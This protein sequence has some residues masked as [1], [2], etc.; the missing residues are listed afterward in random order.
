LVKAGEWSPE[1]VF[2]DLAAGAFGYADLDI[3]DAVAAQVES[4]LAFATQSVSTIALLNCEGAGCP[5]KR[6][7]A[8]FQNNAAPQGRPC[9]YEARLFQGWVEELVT[10][11]ELD[12]SDTATM[13]LIADVVELKILR[14]RILMTMS[15]G[16]G[17][18]KKF[19]SL[20]CEGKTTGPFKEILATYE[21]HPLLDKYL[22]IHNSIQKGLKELL[23]T[24]VER[25]KKKMREKDIGKSADLM[26]SKAMADL[27]KAITE[28]QSMSVVDFTPDKSMVRN[29]SDTEIVDAEFEETGS[30]EDRED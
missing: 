10:N 23:G 8:L 16:Y 13:S 14:R 12:V 9:Y 3:P 4:Y 25:H 26:A 2:S 11:G 29:V 28:R 1:R 19:T 24:P 18:G 15:H 20:L 17:D 27:A 7:C 30:S 21:G 22:A 5:F 6:G